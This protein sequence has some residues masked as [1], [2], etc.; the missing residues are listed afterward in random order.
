MNEFGA[1]HQAFHLELFISSI[2][3]R[4]AMIFIAG[5]SNDNTSVISTNP[6]MQTSDYSTNPFSSFAY[7]KNPFDPLD[8]SEM[9]NR[10]SFSGFGKQYFIFVCL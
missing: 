3:V 10:F 1:Y 7:H 8:M 2:S 6:F 9:Q 5:K 4:I